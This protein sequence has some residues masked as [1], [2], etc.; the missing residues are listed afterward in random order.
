MSALP[1]WFMKA[2]RASASAAAFLA[3]IGV[4]TTGKVFFV[5]SATGTDSTSNSGD[6]PNSPFATL[7]YAIGKCTASK[8]DVIVVFP[9]HSE[10]KSTTG[11]IATLDIAGVTVIGLGTGTEAPTFNLT[12]ASATMTVSGA[13]C[14]ISNIRILSGVADCAVGLTASATADGLTVEDCHFASG[15]LT[16]ELQCAISLAAACTRVTIRR[17]KFETAISA[18][19]GSETS[20]IL[21]VGAA[22][23]LRV[24]DCVAIGN[25]GDAG[26]DADAAASIGVVIKGNLIHNIDSTN[27]LAISLHSSTS[28]IVSDNRLLGL[29][30]NTVP[31]A[32]AGC[33]A[34]ENYTSAAV[35]ESG[36]VRPAVETYA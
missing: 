15:S 8:G 17:C 16:N 12:H 27:G 25:Y 32:C 1:F 23:F 28:G 26:I 9:G 13:N 4:F 2:A 36:I 30:T 22:D 5:D 31:L 33:S 34:H 29:K 24:E 7:D 19:T 18:E 6:D 35:N 14:R 11:D 10:T 3:R 20:A 21:A